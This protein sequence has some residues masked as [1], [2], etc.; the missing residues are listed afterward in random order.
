MSWKLRD[1]EN[2]SD[3]KKTAISSSISKWSKKDEANLL[4]DISYDALNFTLHTDCEQDP[5]WKLDLEDVYNIAFVRVTNRKDSFKERI[6][7]IK[8]E[9][10]L[11]GMHFQSL[12]NS[13]KSFSSDLLFVY[14]DVPQIKARYIRLSLEE[15]TYLHISRVE[16]YKSKYEGCVITGRP[17]SFGCRMLAFLNAFYLANKL[18]YKFYFIWNQSDGNKYIDE[19]T[20]KQNILQCDNMVSKEELFCE[21]FIKEHSLDERSTYYSSVPASRYT[22]E[23]LK[24]KASIYYNTISGDFDVEIVKGIEGGFHSDTHLKELS[25]IYHSLPFTQRYKDILKDVKDKALAL[26]NKQYLFIHSRGGEHI[27]SNSLNQMPDT[28][29]FAHYLP[30]EIAVELVSTYTKLGKGVVLF[31]QNPSMDL[32]IKNY[33]KEA[34]SACDV[35]LIEEHIDANYNINE[36]TF[37]EVNLLS[38]AKELYGSGSSSFNMIGQYIS[39]RRYVKSFFDLYS[40]KEVYEIMLKNF[41][42]LD[43]D[44]Y[45]KAYSM[46]MIYKLSREMNLDINV[47][48]SHIKDCMSYNPNNGFYKLQYIDCLFEKNELKEIEDFLK[49]SLREDNSIADAMNVTLIY[50]AFSIHRYKALFSKYTDIK[51]ISKYPH[52]LLLASLVHYNY[53]K[54]TN[55]SIKFF[56]ESL[57]HNRS[58]PKTLLNLYKE[59]EKHGVSIDYLKFS[60]KKRIHNHLAYKLGQALIE[61][62]KSIKGYIRMPYV[63]SYIKD[64]HKKEQRIYNEK[65]KTN[66]SLKPP[67]ESYPDYEAALKEKQCLTYKLGLALMKADKSWYKGGYIKFYFEAKKLEKEFQDK[68]KGIK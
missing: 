32:K 9:F 37:F 44:N 62:S 8:L 22:L 65:I 59:L 50:P 48:I 6:N 18:N 45:Y 17:D 38:Y 20:K 66:S 46:Y 13:F 15:K 47:S 24:T 58:L 36:R 28:W 30:P 49:Q 54:N 33:F 64:K 2:I 5:W 26:S 52:I 7:S 43:R 63:L 53:F 10:S 12:A 68:K 56:K 3:S 41:D 31:G 35:S 11:D 21:H 67:L 29:M 23:D 1:L 4:L 51:K 39:G 61:N 34:D 19:N 42:V 25:K 14:F 16:I 27:Y 60:A 55:A 57:K 40:D